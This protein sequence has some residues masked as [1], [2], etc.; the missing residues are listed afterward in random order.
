MATSGAAWAAPWTG[1]GIAL[2]LALGP[3]LTPADT[4]SGAAAG[5]PAR[6]A[7]PSGSG[8]SAAALRSDPPDRAPRPREQRQYRLRYTPTHPEN[9]A[10]ARSARSRVAGPAGLL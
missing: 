4:A 7:T 10:A 2:E 1:L 8:S 5:N 3:L 9:R 6:A